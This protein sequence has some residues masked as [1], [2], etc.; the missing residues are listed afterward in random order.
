MAYEYELRRR[1]RRPIKIDDLED[2]L[3]HLERR[4]ELTELELIRHLDLKDI[5]KVLVARGYPILFYR[6]EMRMYT[7]KEERGL[8][9]RRPVEERTKELRE[10]YLASRG[11]V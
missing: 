2:F 7:R 10:V 9:F 3:K 6:R 8:L 1:R 5:A 11:W 4:V